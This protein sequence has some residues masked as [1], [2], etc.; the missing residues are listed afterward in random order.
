MQR[1]RQCPKGLAGQLRRI[2]QQRLQQVYQKGVVEGP[3]QAAAVVQ[4]QM[5]VVV[6]NS[7]ERVRRL[8]YQ[9]GKVY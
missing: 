3:L 2:E 9:Q 6:H 1:K 7:I 8:K 5:V 4:A